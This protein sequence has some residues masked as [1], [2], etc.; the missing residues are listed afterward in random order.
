MDS[1]DGHGEMV[2]VKGPDHR[3]SPSQEAG[4]QPKGLGHS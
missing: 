4:Q 3:L 2:R 1:V